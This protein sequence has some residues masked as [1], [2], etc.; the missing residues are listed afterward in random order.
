[1]RRV[2]NNR[3]LILRDGTEVGT[4]SRTSQGWESRGLRDHFGQ[5]ASSF[6]TAV[7]HLGR[8]S[9]LYLD[10]DGVQDFG[11]VRMV[12][13]GCGGTW[14]TVILSRG[15]LYLYEDHS[16]RKTSGAH[17]AAVRAALQAARS[18]FEKT[19]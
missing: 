16:F 2:S 3:Y 19:L 12:R 6:R 10:A 4:V 17:Q 18:H 7:L 8:Y 14:F 1:M 13:V 5:S 9:G 15:D 11:D